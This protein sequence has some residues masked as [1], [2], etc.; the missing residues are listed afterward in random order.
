MTA[1]AKRLPFSE[2]KE[3][4][5]HYAKAQPLTLKELSRLIGL[6][7]DGSEA[8]LEKLANLLPVI[9]LRIS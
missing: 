8:D 3:I 1:I 5:E 6:S 9:A 2:A 7:Y 4:L